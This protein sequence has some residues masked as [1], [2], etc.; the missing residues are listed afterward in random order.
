M[1]HRVLAIVGPTGVGKTAIAAHV[2]VGTGG[3]IVSIDSRQ[4]YRG[5]E[6]CSNAPTAEEL[7]G[8]LCHLV[9]CLEVGEKLDAAR[10]VRMARPIVDGLLAKGRLALITAGTG[11]YLKALLEGLDLGGHAADPGLR[12][13]L[14][15]QA[16][17]DLAGLHARLVAL[18]PEAEGRVEPTNPVRVVRA[19]ELA[20]RR[21]RGDQAAAATWPPMAALKV[22]LTAPRS[23]LYA[24]IEARTDCLLSRG[25]REEV[26]AL[27][28]SGADLS[29]TA[30]SS[31]G[32]RE[33]AANIEGRMSMEDVRA[34]IVKRTRNYAKRQLTWFRADPEVRWLDVTAHSESDIVE[35]ILEMLKES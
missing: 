30:L 24:W 25:W 18:D 31:I 20:L 10:Y 35:H 34:S 26:E 15:A 3:E 23:R 16:A 14:E 32:V 8:V 27:L 6:I 33:M 22:G 19:T 11:L 13:E 7:G 21:S 28:D 2:G 5:L 17:S 9:G 29:S 4:A 1:P 12:A